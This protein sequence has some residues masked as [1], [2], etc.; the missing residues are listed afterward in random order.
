MY[1]IDLFCFYVEYRVKAG[2]VEYVVYVI[3]DVDDFECRA[4]I[5]QS[6]LRLE[7]YTQTGTGDVFQLAKVQRTGC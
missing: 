5:D 2:I 4:T 3:V 6:F 1:S 7:Q